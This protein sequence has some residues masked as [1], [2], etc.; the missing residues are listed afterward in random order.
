MEAMIHYYLTAP[1]RKSAT[2]GKT[3]VQER[4][5]FTASILGSAHRHCDD[6]EVRAYCHE[7]HGEEPTRIDRTTTH[8]D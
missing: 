3:V 8:L 1:A 7:M 5:P 6:E 4:G 2:T